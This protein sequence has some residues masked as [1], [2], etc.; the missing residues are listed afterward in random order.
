MPSAPVTGSAQLP[1]VFIWSVASC[2]TYADVFNSN[3]DVIGLRRSNV[4][5]PRLRNCDALHRVAGAGTL[6]P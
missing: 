5:S 2:C 1:S 6:P 4:S 3:D